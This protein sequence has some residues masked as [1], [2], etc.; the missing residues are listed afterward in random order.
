MMVDERD[1]EAMA[2]YAKKW[3]FR[4]LFREML[5]A[6]TGEK[7]NDFTICPQFRYVMFFKDPVKRYK[8]ELSIRHGFD[9]VNGT[10]RFVEKSYAGVN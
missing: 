10:K 7:A 9:G 2:E 3:K 6:E 4:V 8:S 1:C 5:L